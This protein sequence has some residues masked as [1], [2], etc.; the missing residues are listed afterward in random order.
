[1]SNEE[2]RE[3]WRRLALPLGISVI[4]NLLLCGAFVRLSAAPPAREADIAVELEGVHPAPPPPPPPALLK[5]I[6]TPPPE[7]PVKKNVVKHEES[8]IKEAK[9]APTLFNKIAR[10]FLRDE[11]PA[12][13]VEDEPPP[14]PDEPPAPVKPV[15]PIEPEKATSVPEPVDTA[16]ANPPAPAPDPNP[17]VKTPLAGIPGEPAKNPGGSPAAPH[18]GGAPGPPASP[19]GGGPGGDSGKGPGGNGAAPG[20][21]LGPG[22]NPGGGTNNIG[23]GAPSGAGPDPGTTGSSMEPGGGESGPGAGPGADPTPVAGTGNAPPANLTSRGPSRGARVVRQS[24]PPYPA[25]AREEGVEGTVQLNVSLDAAGK[26]TAIKIVKSSGD[27]RLDNT[28][29]KEIRG[30]KWSFEAKMEDGV[31][32]ASTIRVNVVFRLE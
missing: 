24:K 6:F 10:I 31:A 16:R 30:K 26:V 19:F 2:Q 17:T 21:T 14:E 3:H 18:P 11:P 12:P 20:I 8:P 32:V 15:K 7:P 4:I 13:P 23:P 29:E 27:R 5:R 25:G 1:M 22:A 28:A 9:S